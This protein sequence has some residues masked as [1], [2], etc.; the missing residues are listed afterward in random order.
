[1]PP[2]PTP[3][4]APSLRLLPAQHLPLATLFGC[5]FALNLLGWRAHNGRFTYLYA[6]APRTS[7]PAAL[8]AC[9]LTP[10]ALALAFAA[11]ATLSASTRVNGSVL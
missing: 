8:L 10:F 4:Y 3:S 9:A 6:D 11:V 2:P 7:A 5:A 1:M